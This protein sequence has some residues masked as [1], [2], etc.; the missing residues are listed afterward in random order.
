MEIRPTLN[1]ARSVQSSIVHPMNNYLYTIGGDLNDNDIT[2]TI[3]Y[4][5]TTNIHQNY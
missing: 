5:S 4:I 1:L 2:D 3:E